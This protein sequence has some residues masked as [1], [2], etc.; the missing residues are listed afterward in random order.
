MGVIGT[1]N[2]LLISMGIMLF[3]PSLARATED[4]Y[5]CEAKQNS[6]NDIPQLSD[7]CPIGNGLWGS[8]PSSERGLFWIQCGMFSNPLTMKDAQAISQHIT[9]DVWLKAESKGYRCLVG[10]YEV[11]SAAKADLDKLTSTSQ[12]K[13]AFIREASRS[14]SS[15]PAQSTKPKEK[16]SAP[17][18]PEVVPPTLSTKEAAKANKPSDTVVARR[19]AK[20]GDKYYAI[21]FL[22]DGY[23]QFYMEY[24]IAWNRLSYE[25]AT[26]VCTSQQ[27]RLP[28]SEEWQLLI[29]SQVM[30]QKQWP[31][32]L[33]YWG[34]SKQGL[35]TSGKVTQLTGTSLLNVVCVK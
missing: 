28:T 25:R 12:Y 3:L 18:K 19:D 21:P 4:D 10:P 1:K 24:G 22:M 23:E 11:Y 2:L 27:M 17:V 34:D 5:I 30:S 35:F 33:P 32:H 20:I 16:P 15:Q 7:S 6:K 26:Q 14:N 31:M 29:D 8:E 13:E 9:Q